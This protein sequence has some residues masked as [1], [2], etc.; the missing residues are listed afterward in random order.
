MEIIAF[1]QFY[2]HPNIAFMKYNNPIAPLK[3]D[4]PP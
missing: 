4:A 2:Y 3:Y 1:L